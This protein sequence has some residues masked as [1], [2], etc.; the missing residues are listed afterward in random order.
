[1]PSPHALI[2]PIGELAPHEPIMLYVVDHLEHEDA[3]DGLPQVEQQARGAK[4]CGND[5]AQC[6]GG[7]T[8]PQEPASR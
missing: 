8:P 4:Q 1:M 7:P 2:P 3:A 6:Q 5:G